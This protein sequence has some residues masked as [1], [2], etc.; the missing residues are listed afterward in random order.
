MTARAFGHLTPVRIVILT[1]YWERSVRIVR[2]ESEL[3]LR[4]WP[5][6]PWSHVYLS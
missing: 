5:V 2:A 1:S 3:L 4:S 6:V